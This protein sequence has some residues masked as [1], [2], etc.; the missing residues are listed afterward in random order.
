LYFQRL[1]DLRTDKELSQ[2]EIGKILNIQQNVYSRYELG[3]RTIPVDLLIIL[4]DF[5]DTSVDFILGRTND[6]AP[7]KKKMYDFK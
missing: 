7:P 4:A 2:V 3:I 1:K 5:Y 6:P